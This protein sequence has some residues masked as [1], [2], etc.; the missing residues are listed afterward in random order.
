MR[1]KK[2]KVRLSA[3]EQQTLRAMLRKGHHSSRVLNRAR[4]LRMA[5]EGKWDKEVAAAVG[6]TVTTVAHI[7]RRY[8]EGGLEAALYD[9]PHRRRP[10]KMDG[11]QEAYLVALACSPP[12][13]GRQRWTLRLL[14]D[15]LVELGVVDSISHV[16]VGDILK[17]RRSALDSQ[18]VVHSPHRRRVRLPD[19][20]DP[21]PL[22]TAPGAWGSE[23]LCG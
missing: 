6:V 7:R 4:V 22:R 17:K 3:E 20:R 12:P 5:H 9:R 15:R 8:A 2:Y 10:P 11:H 23:G 18:A 13:E 1:P 19:G 21:G 14:A 16:T